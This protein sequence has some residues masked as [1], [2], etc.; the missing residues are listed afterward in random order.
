MR[1]ILRMVDGPGMVNWRSWVSLFTL[2]LF[3]MGSFKERERNCLMM[4]KFLRESLKMERK[5]AMGFY[6]ILI[7]WW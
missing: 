5:R 2:V 4:V 1:V 7:G 6:Q 3:K